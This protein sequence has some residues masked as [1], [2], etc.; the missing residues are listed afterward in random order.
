MEV[1]KPSKSDLVPKYMSKEVFEFSRTYV[2]FESQ[3][4]KDVPQDNVYP[5][6][7]SEITT[8]LG[9]SMPEAIDRLSKWILGSFKY[10][11]DA[12]AKQY[13]LNTSRN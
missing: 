7:M 12:L 2:K 9:I 8:R 3:A 10:L 1:P 6:V 11:E 13:G 4:P 5:Y